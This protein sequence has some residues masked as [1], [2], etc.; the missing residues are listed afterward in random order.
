MLIRGKRAPIAGRVCM[1]QV[2]VDVTNIP[3]ACD[4]D[5]VTLIGRDGEEEITMESLANMFGGFNYEIPCC[6]T[7]R[8]ARVYY[9]DGVPVASMNYFSET[10]STES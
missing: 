2:M 10:S 8:I 9:R 4:Y 6:F 5:E 1:D 3:D 7:K